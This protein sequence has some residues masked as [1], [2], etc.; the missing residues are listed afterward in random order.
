MRRGQLRDCFAGVGVKRLT[1]VDADPRRSNQH[2]I[3]TTR[4][5][6]NQ[7]LGDA[8]QQEFDV[9]YIWLGEGRDGLVWDGKATHYD[10]RQQ[11]AAR[12]AEWR[13]YYPTNPVTEAMQEGDI[14]FLAR[15]RT[16]LLYFIVAQQGSSSQQQFSWLFGLVPNGDAF[17]SR[18][19]ADQGPEL[20]FAAR[21]ILDAIGM[22]FEE[23]DADALDALIGQFGMEFPKTAEFSNL[24]RETMRTTKAEDNPDAALVAWVSREEAL[25]RRLERRI[26]TERLK[27]GFGDQDGD[28][29]V[30]SFLQFSLGVQNRRK[31]RMGQSLEHHLEAVFRT[32]KV[33]YV[34]NALTENN[35]RPD[36]LFPDEDTYRAAPSTGCARLTMLGAKSS[37][38]ERWRQVLAEAAKIPNKHLLTLEPGISEAQTSQMAQSGLQLVVPQPIQTSY[39]REQCAWLWT[40]D[41]FIHH[42]QT[43]AP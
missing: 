37:C 7:F 19:I 8:N 13:L 16:G 41:K 24:A 43:R 34:R 35:H 33:A 25:F 15:S 36:F 40:L 28:I 17:V 26:I 3:G 12:A 5:M 10:A 31:A 29:N 23:P 4:A 32:H 42:L 6:R 9:R 1:A 38:K 11:Q 20:D 39:T 27:K 22:E 18:E 21:F 2:E 14:L 30:D